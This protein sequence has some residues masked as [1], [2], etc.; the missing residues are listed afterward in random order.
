MYM[1]NKV[2]IFAQ[3]KIIFTSK[4]RNQQKHCLLYVDRRFCK[5]YTSFVGQPELERIYT[6]FPS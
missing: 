2:K 3:N 4:G 5:A 6:L 1:R